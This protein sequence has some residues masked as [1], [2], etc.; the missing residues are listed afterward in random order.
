[1][2]NSFDQLVCLSGLPRTGSTLLSA[3]LSQNPAIHAEGNSGLCQ[4]MWDTQQSC[5]HGAYEMLAANSRLDSVHDIVSQLPHIYY[6]RNRQQEKIVVD[7]C[8]T[9]TL[10]LNIK[11]IDE[12][13]G[14]DT[15]VVVLVRPVV[16]IVKSF[17]K[18][19]KE[20]GIYTE[21]LERDLFN[22]GSDPLTRPLAGVYAA[23]QDTSGRFLFVSYK[24]LVEDT[25]QTLKGIYEFCGWDKFIHNTN[26]IKQK[27]AEND[28]IYG[29]KGMHSVRKKVGC[30]KN[31]TQ[32]MDE[33]VK[34]CME[35]DKALNLID[36]AANTEANYGI[37]N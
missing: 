6:K 28:E 19:Y 15:K 11:M 26:N 10:P 33:T 36:T 7:K 8:R 13:I 14:K 21:Q 22:P 37:F 1:M 24:D 4:I 16:E 12:F 35:L 29:L 17:V 23:Q 34:K 32:L 20:N 3:L 25:A 18:L 2:I 9:W 5:R 30:R 27:Y 31:H